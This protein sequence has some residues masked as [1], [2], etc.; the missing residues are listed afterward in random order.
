METLLLETEGGQ[1]GL[2]I[3]CEEHKKATKSKK[4]A[5]K[6]NKYEKRR[7]KA[8]LAANKGNEKSVETVHEPETKSKVVDSPTNTNEND[9]EVKERSIEKIGNEIETS[10]NDAAQHGTPHKK[11]TDKSPPPLS[12]QAPSTRRS[13]KVHTESLQNEEERARHM[14]EFHARPMEMDRRCGAV[15]S[16][17]PSK[18]SSH[19]FDS[20]AFEGLHPR[21]ITSL[22]KIGVQQPTLI[23]TRAVQ[24]LQ[25]SKPHNL[26]IQSETG[27]G[28]TLAYLL[29]ILQVSTLLKAT[30]L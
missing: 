1:W 8:R 18:E 17:V 5:K 25:T 27:S 20:C 22:T 9:Q 21:I 26:F 24:A 28:K 14:A 30:L 13:R 15:S 23:Q 6:Y 19:I 2:N 11:V 7:A 29:P 4:K 16:I 3:V 10:P 12:E